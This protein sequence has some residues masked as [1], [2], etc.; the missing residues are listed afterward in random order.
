MSIGAGLE[1]DRSAVDGLHQVVEVSQGRD[2]FP[3]APDN[4]A[5]DSGTPIALLGSYPVPKDAVPK[6]NRI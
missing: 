5:R 3:G 1:F 6:E 4:D 2:T